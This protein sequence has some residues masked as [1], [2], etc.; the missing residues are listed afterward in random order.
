[1]IHDSDLHYTNWN[2]WPMRVSP[3]NSANINF[4]RLIKE[5]E[6][7]GIPTN[8]WNKR[9]EFTI[10]TLLLLS[11]CCLT[12]LKNVVVWEKKICDN[13]IIHKWVLIFGAHMYHLRVSCNE[14]TIQTYIA[15]IPITT[16][17]PIWGKVH[18]RRITMYQQNKPPNPVVV[19]L[20][21]CFFRYLLI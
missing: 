12:I 1:M 7:Q 5:K 15:Q 14:K 3:K 10:T 21:V 13:A 18:Q 6:K 4:G 17:T 20:R 19:C 8:N 16:T 2:T 9:T 11:C